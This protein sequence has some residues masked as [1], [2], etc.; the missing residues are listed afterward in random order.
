MLGSLKN[1]ERRFAKREDSIFRM[2]IRVHWSR[3][4][5]NLPFFLF[6]I[7]LFMVETREYWMIYRGPWFGSSPA[8]STPFPSASYLSF[9]F[10]LCVAGRYHLWRERGGGV[11][12]S[13]DSEKAWSSTNHSILSGWDYVL[14]NGL[15]TLLSVCRDWADVWR[16]L[17][18]P[19]PISNRINSPIWQPVCY[20]SW[21]WSRKS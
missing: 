4:E 18:N 14:P 2:R 3:T 7:F 16:V 17:K 11:A 5:E 20:S 19:Q 1:K 8:P 13:Y 10:F 6:F 9:S 15:A 21:S 12:E